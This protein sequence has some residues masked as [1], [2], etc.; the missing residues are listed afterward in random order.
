MNCCPL[1]EADETCTL[2]NEATRKAKKS[3]KCEEC[4]EEI[5]PGDLYSYSTMLFDGSWTT[6]KMC[7]SCKEI[8]DHFTCGSR[9]VGQLWEELEEYFFPDMKAGGPCMEGLSPANKARLFDSRL[10]WLFERDS[11]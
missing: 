7:L 4:Q 3:H 5:K 11:D 8:G 9:I 2:Y 6:T 10:V 1:S